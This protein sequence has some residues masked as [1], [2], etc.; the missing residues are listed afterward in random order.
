MKRLWLY[1]LFFVVVFLLSAIA[2]QLGA[3]ELVRAYVF[4][5]PTATIDPA[6]EEYAKVFEDSSLDVMWMIYNDTKDTVIVGFVNLFP[7]SDEQAKILDVVMN[8]MGENRQLQKVIFWFWQGRPENDWTVVLCDQA[9]C[10]LVAGVGEMS[11]Q[12]KQW[13]RYVVGRHWN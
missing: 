5:Q 8:S 11:M 6:L 4:P 13:Q 2:L 12:D 7:L 3:A 10:R 1:P 9:S